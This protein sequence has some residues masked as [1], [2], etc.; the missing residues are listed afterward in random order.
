MYNSSLSVYLSS[1]SNNLS[2]Y[3]FARALTP[4]FRKYI[5]KLS[6]ARI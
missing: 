1:L 4:F 2:N 5:L 6:M 3:W